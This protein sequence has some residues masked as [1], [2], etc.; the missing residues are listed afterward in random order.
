M[1]Q[2]T[3]EEIKELA[4][5]IIGLEIK[6]FSY[7]SD[8]DFFVI[9]TDHGKISFRFIVDLTQRDIDTKKKI[10]EL[11]QRLRESDQSD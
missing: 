11:E 8:D 7:E 4:S 2:Y 6:K 10:D 3:Q 1:T 9:E 5:A